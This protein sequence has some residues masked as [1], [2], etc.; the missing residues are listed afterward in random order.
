MFSAGGGERTSREM[1]VDLL[2]ALP[3]DSIVRA[4]G[5]SGNPFALR[6]GNDPH[7]SVYRDLAQ[8]TI[9]RFC[10]LGPSAGPKIEIAE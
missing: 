1:I 6:N 8:R 7:G 3:L 9:D 2:G 4:G 5:D 10:E